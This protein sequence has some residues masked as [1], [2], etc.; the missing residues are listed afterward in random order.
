MFQIGQTVSY[1]TMGICTIEDI[2]QEALSRAGT[3]KQ[4]YYVLRPMATPTCI[5]YVPTTNKTLTARMRPVMTKEQIDALIDGVHGRDMEWIEDTRQRTDA[6]QKILSG[7]IS[8][9]LLLLVACLYTEKQKKSREGKKFCATDEKIMSG[10]ERMIGEEFS[11]AL[12]IPPNDVP[13]YIA[14]RMEK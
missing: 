4:E 9:E 2:R 1:G 3:Q 12:N 10:A 6:W 8:G 11:C 5:T 14:R 7:G 13:A